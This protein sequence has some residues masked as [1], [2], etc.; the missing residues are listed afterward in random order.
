IDNVTACTS[1]PVSNVDLTRLPRNQSE[2]HI[3]KIALTTGGADALEC[4]LRKIGI[5]DS[6]FTPEAGSGRV[7]FFGGVN[8]TNS[9]NATLGGASF[10]SVAAGWGDV[11]NLRQHEMILHSCDG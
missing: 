3:P 9:F 5:S 1:Q 6:E 10:T 2:G 7:N 4:L 11:A 8:G